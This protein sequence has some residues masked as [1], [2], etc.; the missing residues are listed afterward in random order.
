MADEK[1]VEAVD[2]AFTL[3]DCF[4]GQEDTL[5]LAELARRSGFYKSTIL[6]I[7]VSLERSGYMLRQANGGY[8]LGP[9]L[10]RLGSLY[11]QSFE[12]GEHIRPELRALVD[13]TQETASFFVREGA[14]RVCLYRREPSRSIVHQLVEG[15]QLPMASMGASAQ[16]LLA[17]SEDMPV[18]FAEVREA[19]Y[20]VS[21][22]A[23]DAEVAAVSVPFLGDDDGLRGALAVSGLIYR[24]DDA[25]IDAIRD[26]LF[27]SAERLSNSYVDTES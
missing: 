20:A 6:R 17:W 16:V 27:E 5:S 26:A 4:D 21:M 22:G 10:W 23:R 14:N 12:L 2:R 25:N 8:R 13:A 7:A 9:T 19:G 1:G 11:R 15:A 18:E 24:F 3:L